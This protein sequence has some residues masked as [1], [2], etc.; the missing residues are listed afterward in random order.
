MLGHGRAG[1]ADLRQV[2]PGQRCW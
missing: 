1:P 2:G